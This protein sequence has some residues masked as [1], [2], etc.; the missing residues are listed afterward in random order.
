MNWADNVSH[1]ETLGDAVFE[2]AD[3]CAWK[4]FDEQTFDCSFAVFLSILNALY[5]T[6][7]VEEA[8]RFYHFFYEKKKKFTHW[9][10]SKEHAQF[11]DINIDFHQFDPG[12]AAI[13]FLY[14]LRNEM[15]AV[16][17]NINC[18]AT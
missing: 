4:Y 1:F 15:D 10:M 18:S 9:H 16:I 2:T 12:S 7:Q 14:I 11:A 13:A 8:L 17:A 5:W 6:N 3:D